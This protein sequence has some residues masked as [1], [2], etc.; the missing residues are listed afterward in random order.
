M[1]FVDSY[2]EEIEKCDDELIK[3]LEKRLKLSYY[4]NKLKSYDEELDKQSEKKIIEKLKNRIN[5]RLELGQDTNLS[6]KI[7]EDIWHKICQYSRTL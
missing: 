7:I 2:N 5:T 6:E 1:N 4:K 3:L